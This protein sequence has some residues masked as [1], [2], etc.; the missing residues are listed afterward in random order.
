VGITID[1][2]TEFGGR[3]ER[4]LREE[5]VV[6]I[7]TVDRRGTPQPVP[8]WFVWSDGAILIST[9]HRSAKLKNLAHHGRASVSFNAT[10]TGGDVVVLLGDAVV[11][12]L[13][14]T[15]REDYDSK[16]SDAMAGLGMTPDQ[17]HAEYDT[18]I[19][20]EPDRLR[21]F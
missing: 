1:T 5:E 18:V 10:T 17:F 3:V 21:G 7:T 13:S 9:P 12:A 19:R 6:W 16:Y 4:R 2:S 20:F 8:V 14:T 15:E 11:D